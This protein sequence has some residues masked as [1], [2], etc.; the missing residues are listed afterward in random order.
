MGGVL[1]DA[2]KP[3][4]HV[5][6]HAVAVQVPTRFGSHVYAHAAQAMLPATSLMVP[7]AQAVQG[8]VLGPVKP[9]EHKHCEMVL[10]PTAVVTVL[11]GHDVHDVEPVTLV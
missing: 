7:A 10:A 5:V 9:G 4:A 8:P 3:E 2:R 6:G 1:P 11:V